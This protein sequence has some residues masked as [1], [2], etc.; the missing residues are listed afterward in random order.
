MD[1]KSKFIIILLILLVITIVIM[2][3]FAYKTY[4]K[5][6]QFGNI[7]VP[8]GNIIENVTSENKITSNNI[9]PSEEVNNSVKTVIYEFTS[10]DN[11][12][13]QGNPGILKIFEL[14]DT[15]MDFEYNHGW[16][17]AESTIDRNVSGIAKLNEQNLYEFVENIDGHKY[18]I[19]IKFS[20]EMITLSE[21][22][23]GDLISKINLWS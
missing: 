5:T 15:Q 10:S 21:Y 23:D 2:A 11:F 16:N 19:I 8:S 3:C 22:I 1:K 12:A 7:F 13:A 17:F 18:S 6:N 14:T 9:S 4:H 20:E